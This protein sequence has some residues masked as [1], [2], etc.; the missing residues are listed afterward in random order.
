MK[1]VVIIADGVATVPP[2]VAREY[3]ILVAPFHIKMDGRD[4]L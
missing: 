3:G 2:E 4:Y 1:E